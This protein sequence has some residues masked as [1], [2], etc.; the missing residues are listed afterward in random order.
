LKNKR[1]KDP[2]ITPKIPI[3]LKVHLQPKV[4]IDNMQKELK[5]D[6]KRVPEL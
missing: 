2:K 6:P 5:A 3:P 1:I 4:E